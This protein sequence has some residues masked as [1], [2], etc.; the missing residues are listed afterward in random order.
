[1]RRVRRSVESS[2]RRRGRGEIKGRR[3]AYRFSALRRGYSDWRRGRCPSGGGQGACLRLGGHCL[4]CG[5]S[6]EHAPGIHGRKSLRSQEH[7][8]ART[9]EPRS[10]S[11][12]ILLMNAAATVQDHKLMATFPGQRR[13]SR[14]AAVRGN[15]PGQ[16]PGTMADKMRCKP[17][18]DKDFGTAP[19]GHPPFNLLCHAAVSLGSVAAV[20]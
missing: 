19:V 20:S 8:G 9:L 4:I 12:M 6:H 14:A 11:A 1:M 17:Y 18:D 16:K 2:R 15:F 5:R 3:A 7:R 13:S 10:A